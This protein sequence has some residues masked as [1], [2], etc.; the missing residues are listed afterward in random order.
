MKKMLRF[1][2]SDRIDVNAALEHPY[3]AQ[4]HDPAA[5]LT[6]PKK[7]CF[8]F[9]DDNLTGDQVR[10]RMYKEIKAYYHP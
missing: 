2:P 5:E 1:N 9:E 7:I 10:A 6:C 3:L 4:L 8:G